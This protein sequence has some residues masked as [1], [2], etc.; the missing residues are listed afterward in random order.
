MS[1]RVEIDLY[2]ELKSIDLDNK[3]ELLKWF[4]K[5]YYSYNNMSNSKEFNESIYELLKDKYKPI[6]EDQ[7]LLRI[8]KG[9]NIG[10]I[11]HTKKIDAAVL[12]GQIMIGIKGGI[13]IT[14]DVINELLRYHAKYNNEFLNEK[15]MEEMHERVGTRVVV[16]GRHEK[17]SFFEEGVLE[18]VDDYNNL[19]LS[20]YE[21]KIPFIGQEHYIIEIKDK[22][23][24]TILFH[25]YGK[26]STADLTKPDDIKFMKYKIMGV[27]SKKSKVK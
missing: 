17:K 10:T 21:G 14:R 11:E 5:L 12:I 20:N 9:L 24:E 18:S 15:Y 4:L 27:K 19:T 26:I 16:L 25:N 2:K 23:A 13:G 22:M 1:N 3:D 6:V 7:N 8:R